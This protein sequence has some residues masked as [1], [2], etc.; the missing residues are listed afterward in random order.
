MGGEWV[1]CHIIVF[2]RGIPWDIPWGLM[3]SHRTSHGMPMH[4]VASRGTCRGIA[5]GYIPR[6]PVGC[7]GICRGLS[8]GTEIKP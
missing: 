6:H 5:V 3:L 4:V 7:G 1:A 8:R 2:S